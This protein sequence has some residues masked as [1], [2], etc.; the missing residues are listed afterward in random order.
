MSYKIDLGGKEPNEYCRLDL[1]E[2]MF[3]VQVMS[4]DCV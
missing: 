1:L 4:R 3:K 2:L